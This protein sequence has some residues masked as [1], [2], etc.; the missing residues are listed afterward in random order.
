MMWVF[1]KINQRFPRLVGAVLDA[2]Q[3]RA[4]MGK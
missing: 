4:E 3:V 1:W 2:C